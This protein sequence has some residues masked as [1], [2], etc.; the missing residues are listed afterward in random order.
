MSSVM[1]TEDQC[2]YIANALQ[3]HF[4]I[5]M[6]KDGSEYVWK[7]HTSITLREVFKIISDA[8]EESYNDNHNGYTG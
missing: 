3:S 5:R 6:V 4:Y 8:I 1:L 2:T 7:K